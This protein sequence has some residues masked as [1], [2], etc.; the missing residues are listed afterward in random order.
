M[1]STVRPP[2]R[3]RLPW[4][5]PW[6]LALALAERCGS[7][8]LVL[9]EGDDSLLGRRALL[10]VEPLAVVRCDGL[11]GDADAHD[12]FSRLAELRATALPW[13]GWLGYEAGAWVEPDSHWQRSDMASLWAAHHDPLIHFDRQQR[14]CWLEGHD[15][16]RIER[17]AALIEALPAEA[18]PEPHRW[19]SCAAGSP[20]AT[21]FRPTS[22]PA[23][24]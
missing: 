22:P 10:G 12:P 4:R 14:L 3:R 23:V 11:P 2:L 19:S 18:V 7:D 15:S 5:D 1:A 24:N 6:S 21:S 20:P 9:L 17:L 16:H 13:L 8:G